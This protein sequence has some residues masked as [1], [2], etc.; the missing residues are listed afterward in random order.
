MKKSLRLHIED[1]LQSFPKYMDTL[2]ED[3][4][5]QLITSRRVLGMFRSCLAILKV[6]GKLEPDGKKL[7]ELKYWNP[8]KLKAA[9]IAS[10]LNM[11]APQVKKYSEAICE[12]I[13]RELGWI[14][15]I[16]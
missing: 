14:S 3:P 7:V 9:E 15:S 12:A 16:V 10:Q 1:E 8:E 13:A 4:T 6:V 11:T 2:D 5:K